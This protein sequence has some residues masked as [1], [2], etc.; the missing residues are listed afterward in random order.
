MTD[1]EIIDKAK[2]FM[3]KQVVEARRARDFE[4]SWIKTTDDLIRHYQ[5]CKDWI[6]STA[7]FVQTI[8][9]GYG[10]EICTFANNCVDEIRDLYAS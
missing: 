4:Y 7:M 5:C 6:C 2:E 8:T 1:R 9:K 10:D 3:K